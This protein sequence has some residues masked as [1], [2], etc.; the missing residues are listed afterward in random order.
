MKS[1]HIIITV[2]FPALIFMGFSPNK[3]GENDKKVTVEINYQS[4]TPNKSINILWQD[5]LTALEALQKA[6]RVTTYTNKQHVIVI[7]IDDE[8]SEKGQTAWYY[9]VNNKTADVLAIDKLLSAGDTV[10]W[11][12]RADTCS[13]KVYP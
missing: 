13:N 12:H 5:G 10:S 7:A 3:R 1:L 8:H 2:F 4:L 11:I 6:S 9:E